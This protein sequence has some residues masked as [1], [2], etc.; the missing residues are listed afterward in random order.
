MIFSFFIFFLQLFFFSSDS[1]GQGIF[2]LNADS[3]SIIQNV[4]F[5]NLLSINN[6]N[7]SLTGA[8]TLYNSPIKINETKFINIQSEDALN[9]I[10]S[11]FSMTNT[12]FDNNAFD[13][14]DCD[15][16]LGEIN[17]SFFTKTGEKE[18]SSPLFSATIYTLGIITIFNLI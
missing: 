2:V 4:I 9:I 15:F 12:Y 3:T 11:E 10:S 17:Y 16:C 7:R 6:N 5:N 8:I 14:F 18:N 13:A 1:S